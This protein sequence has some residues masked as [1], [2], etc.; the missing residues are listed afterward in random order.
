MKN[1]SEVYSVA[2]TSGE[3]AE[4]L[5]L[6]EADAQE[7]D[8]RSQL[9]T[10]IID[11]AK[12]SKLTQAQI[13]KKAG[14]ARTRITALLNRSRTDMSTDFMLRVLSALG[15]KLDIKIKKITS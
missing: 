5:D 6:S 4:L 11:L 14:T 15:Y 1:K 13:A 10:K 2:R 9:N 8:F 12:K 3:L 7:W